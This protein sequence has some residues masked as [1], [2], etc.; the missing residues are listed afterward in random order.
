[1]INHILNSYYGM[2]CT[3][4]SRFYKQQGRYIN[5]ATVLHSLRMWEVY[6]KDKNCAYLNDWLHDVLGE[7]DSSD[8]VKKVT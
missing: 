7:I 6:S 2:G 8:E 3:Q 4:I 5:H 1:M